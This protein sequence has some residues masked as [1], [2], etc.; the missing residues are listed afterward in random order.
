VA[1]ILTSKLRSFL[2]HRAAGPVLALAS[3]LAPGCG[4]TGPS[5][6][7]THPAGA[8]ITTTVVGERPFGLAVSVTGVVYV[9]QLDASAITRLSLATGAIEGTVS[10]GAVPTDVEFDASGATAYVTNQFSGNVGVVTVA[11]GVESATIPVGGT[12]FRV[13]LQPGGSR[14]YASSN[15]DSVY[16]VNASS[17]TV[18]A[19]IKVGLDPNGFAFNANGSRLW[20]SNQS[21]G[22]ITEL[23]TATNAVTR[24][25]TVG[26]TPQDIVLS[27]DGTELYVANLA[28]GVQ[29]WNVSSSTLIT[30]IPLQGGGFGLAMTPDRAQLYAAATLSGQVY[31]IDRT[32]REVI[33]ILSVGGLPRRIAFSAKGDV[34]VFSNEAGS[35]AFVR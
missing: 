3:L 5:D 9:T 6:P 8:T 20:V 1:G 25:L 19:R 24:T 11:S 15:S 21:D 16:A 28:N 22:T 4:S 2:R 30:T 32:T 12:P 13:A 26:G 31:V 23:N 27:P 33:R 35:V 14:V 10:V 18:T 7:P 29:V 34:A 17:N